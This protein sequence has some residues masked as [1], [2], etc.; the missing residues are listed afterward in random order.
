MKSFNEYK[1][2]NLEYNFIQ[3]NGYKN[4]KQNSNDV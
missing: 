2:E 1:K 4:H 3:E